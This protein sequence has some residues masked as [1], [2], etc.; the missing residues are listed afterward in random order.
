MNDFS[1]FWSCY[2]YLQ[3]HPK[4]EQNRKVRNLEMY[5]N[6]RSIS[7]NYLVIACYSKQLCFDFVSIDMFWQHFVDA[8]R[9]DPWRHSW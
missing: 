3:H 2:V 4:V 6:V 1:I 7:S 9:I 5:G 8:R